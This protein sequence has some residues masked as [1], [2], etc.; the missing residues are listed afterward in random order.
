MGTT[1]TGT[2]PQ[3][4]YDSLIKVTDN[5]PISGTAKF[6]SDG[7]GNDLPIAVSTTNVGIGTSSP[8]V[9]GYSR[10][11]TISS[12]NSA[13]ELTSATNVV[14]ATLAS[15]AQGLAVEGVG[16][17]GIRIFTSTSGAT[18][19]RM[20]IDSTGNVGIGTSTPAGVL[21]VAGGTSTTNTIVLGQS[22]NANIASRHS[23]VFNVDRNNDVGGRSI[24]FRY[25]GNGYSGGTNIARFTS[26]GLCFGSD[27]AAA[28]A[29]DDY[30]EGTFSPTIIGTTTAGTASYTVQTGAYT[31]IGR[32]VNFQ[33]YIVWTG[34]T[35]TGDF[36]VGGLP[37]TSSATPNFYGA[38]AIGFLNLTLPA[39]GIATAN[40]DNNSTNIDLRSYPAGG[41]AG[42]AFAYDADGSLIINGSYYV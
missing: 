9:S 13:L 23:I 27:S 1:L 25:G 36:R 16:T 2:T 35:G 8:N 6:L 37:F 26:A 5:G 38:C 21:E 20:R 4:T 40:V 11:L 15:N 28:N 22:D 39:L 14:Q 29:L 18:T 41:G 42:A 12:A 3:D 19:E 30:E 17:S 33:F 31:K 34:G 10:A 32:L 24:D 7:L